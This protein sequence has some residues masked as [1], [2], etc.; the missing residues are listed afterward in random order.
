M[1]SGEAGGARRGW[2]QEGRA[3]NG[4]MLACVRGWMRWACSHG[5]CLGEEDK[6]WSESAI[7]EN[8]IVAQ[9]PGG[10][11]QAGLG[12]GEKGA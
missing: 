4:R 1:A 11:R 3:L 5:T 8:A 12:A 2:R 9:R 7:V 6:G 10:R